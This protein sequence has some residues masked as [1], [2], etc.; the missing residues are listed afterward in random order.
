MTATEIKAKI[1]SILDQVEVGEE[2]LI[3]RHGRAVAKLVPARGP[4]ALRGVSSGTARTADP[5]DEIFSTGVQWES[6]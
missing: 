6:S 4:H 2:V 5:S 1:L 3:T